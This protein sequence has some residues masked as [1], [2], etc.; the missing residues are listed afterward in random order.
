MSK[1]TLILAFIFGCAIGC[2]RNKPINYGVSISYHKCNVAG[3]CHV[4]TEDYETNKQ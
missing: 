4:V 2:A 3:D 1:L